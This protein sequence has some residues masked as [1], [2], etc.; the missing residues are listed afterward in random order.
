MWENP[1]IGE[2]PTAVSA[3]LKV[4][5]G[6]VKNP[7]QDPWPDGSRVDSYLSDNI[8][9]QVIRMLDSDAKA[10]EEAERYREAG[11]ERDAFERWGAI[12][13]HQFPAYS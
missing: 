5:G 6:W 2:W 4:M 7:R 1:A 13:R 3:T 11:R 12:Y 10:A 9:Q 8:R